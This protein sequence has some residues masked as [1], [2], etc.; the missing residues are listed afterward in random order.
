M[1]AEVLYLRTLRRQE[2]VGTGEKAL[3]Q[4]KLV[5]DAPLPPKKD[6]LPKGPG[7]ELLGKQNRGH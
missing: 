6:R 4:L 7:L 1:K 2:L 3:L 5:P